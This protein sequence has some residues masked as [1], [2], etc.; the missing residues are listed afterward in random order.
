MSRFTSA[1]KAFFRILKDTEFAR[2][3]EKLDR[4]ELCEPS[5][6]MALLQRQGRF[7]DF[8]R[9]DISGYGDAQ[10]GG[11]ARTIHEGCNKVLKEYIT[12]EPVVKEEEGASITVPE[13]FDP[14][15]IKLVGN[16]AGNPPFKGTVAHHGWKITSSKIPAVPKGHD[17]SIINAA[18]VEL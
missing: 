4:G 9:E 14:S 12:I 17:P 8:I 2:M 11:V 10:I 16:V 6:I 3:F 5:S 13:G 7:V 1:F 15:A 18:E